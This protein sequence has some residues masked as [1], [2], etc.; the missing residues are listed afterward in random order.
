MVRD[1]FVKDVDGMKLDIFY[2]RFA[3]NS[4]DTKPTR[5]VAMGSTFQEV[6]TG[7]RYRFNEASGE[8]VES[9]TYD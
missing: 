1:I 5:D 4:S 2:H 7:K 9:D 3:G 6:D 8:W